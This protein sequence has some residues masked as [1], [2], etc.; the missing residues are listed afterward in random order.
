MPM[1]VSIF[2]NLSCFFCFFLP[3]IVLVSE[4]DDGASVRGLQQT[5]DD[6]IEL[7]GTRLP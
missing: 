7:A 4:H 1:L 6:L 3:D 5:Y 2:V